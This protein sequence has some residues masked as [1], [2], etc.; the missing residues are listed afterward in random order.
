MTDHYWLGSNPV[1]CGDSCRVVAPKATVD[2]GL[3]KAEDD[4]FWG[5]HTERR[6][7]LASYL[8]M[9]FQEGKGGRSQS[10]RYVASTSMQKNRAVTVPRDY[11]P[12]NFEWDDTLADPLD[13]KVEGLSFSDRE[14]LHFVTD[15]NLFQDHMCY[16]IGDLDARGF[17]LEEVSEG[18]TDGGMR[19]VVTDGGRKQLE[20][21]SIDE[22][23]PE[24]IVGEDEVLHVESGEV[25][26][27]EEVKNRLEDAVSGD[28]DNN[29]DA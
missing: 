8:K 9:P 25:L 21:T 14:T 15:T 3:L 7:A 24:A 23:V 1:S 27:I 29:Q 6:W 26:P 20:A 19:W 22:V 12:D 17:I 4:T 16:V 13:E 28:K 11:F 2:L 5:Y 10:Y 18:I